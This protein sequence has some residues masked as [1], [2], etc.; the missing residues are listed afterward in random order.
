MARGTSDEEIKLRK[1]ARRRLIGAI[2]LTTLVVVALPMILD[3]EPRPVGDDIEVQ[4]PSPD[5][6][7]YAPKP[8]ASGAPGPSGV[9]ARPDAVST[10]PAAGAASA[11]PGSQS[12]Q[13]P[14]SP[15]TQSTPA[16]SAPAQSTP[17]KAGGAIGAAGPATAS[18]VRPEPALPAV[19]GTAAKPAASAPS[20][21]PAGTTPAT[22]ATQAGKAGETYV[23]QLGAFSEVE[24][25]KTRHALLVKAGVR[26]YMEVIKTPTGDKTRVRAGPFPTRE[27]ADTVNERLKTLD[28]T[29]GV[30]VTRRY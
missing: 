2:A 28:M 7:P 11:S 5:A 19:S 6:G 18:S 16:Q 20:P 21:P 22:P 17:S 25:A 10:A 9:P 14:P 15:P 23:I 4:I 3:D 8:L 13:S 12:R 24:R 29:D 30:V 1:R 26:S 27:A